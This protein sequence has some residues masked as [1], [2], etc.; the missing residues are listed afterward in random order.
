M[1]ET[2]ASLQSCWPE[3]QILEPLDSGRYG[4]VYKAV[5][6]ESPAV[7]SAIK[8]IPIPS[9]PSRT[10]YLRGEGKT[11]KQIRW[12]YRQT[13]EE[14]CREI[15]NMEVLKGT[16]H[17]V[18]L[19]DF[20]IIPD[21]DGPGCCICIRME[22][23]KPL[24]EYLCDKTLT[25]S[26]IIQIGIDISDALNLCHQNGII[27]L[28][29]KPENIFVNDRLPSGVLYKLGDFGIS[30]EMDA[31]GEV[32][33][34]GTPFYMAP[35]TA[36]G[37]TPDA[38]SDLYSLGLTLYQLSNNGR[39]PF[40]SDRPLHH[41][42]EKEIAL[43]TRLSGVPI[44][45]PAHASKSFELILQKACAFDPNQRFASA[46]EMSRALRDCQR[47]STGGYRLRQILFAMLPILSLIALCFLLWQGKTAD[48]SADPTKA[49]LLPVVDSHISAYAQLQNHLDSLMTEIRQKE[50]LDHRTGLVLIPENLATLQHFESLDTFSVPSWSLDRSVHPLTMTV[51]DD[52]GQWI[53]M[54]GYNNGDEFCSVYV[55]EGVYHADS[56]APD[57]LP[58]TVTLNC[59]SDGIIDC[60]ICDAASH[61]LLIHSIDFF[62][63]G[64]TA[65]VTVEY[66]AELDS[67]ML[68]FSPKGL[69][70]IQ[71]LYDA[72]GNLCFIKRM[73][74]TYDLSNEK[75][76]IE[77]VEIIP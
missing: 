72:D 23:L 14:C 58:R 42:E 77:G 68:I 28:D 55:G 30:A 70:R 47:K 57:G 16:S 75:P 49:P 32:L 43:K 15:R 33:P 73:Q 17:I 9:D 24:I 46:A 65:S 41:S 71:A 21:C 7:Q 48:H 54:L 59:T 76:D 34:C 38:R 60:L 4:T 2:K 19:E 45:P 61:K 44:P 27:H 36:E 67:W 56:S 66:H 29:V 40:L 26:E 25:E 37:K 10:D 63:T 50:L 74:E 20:A 31:S 39:L 13:A 18:T 1:S 53:P 3:W 69:P 35:E 52:S 5:H 22:L 8:M 51:A 62:F 64:N 6:R 11:E 12:I